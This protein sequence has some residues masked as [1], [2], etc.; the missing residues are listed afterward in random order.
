MNADGSGLEMF[1]RGVRNTVG[2]DWHPQHAA[3]CGSPT[4]AATCWATTCRPTSSTTRRSAGRAL[5]LSVLPRRRRSPIRSSARKRACSE[6]TPPAQKL[7]PHVAA[8]G[9]RFYTGTQ[10]PA[11]LPQPDLHRRARLVEP[12]QEDRLPRH[13][14]D[15]RRERQARSRYEP[16]AEGWLQGEQRLGPAG[17]RAGRARRLAAGVR[18]RGGRDLPDQLPPPVAAGYHN[19]RAK[20]RGGHEDT[21]R[22]DDDGRDD[23]K[24]I[25]IGAYTGGGTKIGAAMTGRNQGRFQPQLKQPP[26][27]PGWPAL[28]AKPGPPTETLQATLLAEAEGAMATPPVRMA[29]V[30]ATR[31]ARREG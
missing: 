3:S 15:A 2:F 22:R 21:V 23:R 7:G 4:T 16:F 13:A 10:F 1:A 17:R 24:R 28:T 29:A 14:G 26:R 6:F 12:Q 8:L 31:A 19:A 25:A 9:M 30:A 5:R 20:H 18:R 27:N 11:E